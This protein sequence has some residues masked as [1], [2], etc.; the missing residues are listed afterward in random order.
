MPRALNRK[1]QKN[2]FYQPVKQWQISVF[3]IRDVIPAIEEAFADIALAVLSFEV[4]EDGPEWCVD[5]I[6]D[7]MPNK[8]GIDARLALVS[9]MVDL[10]SFR[11]AVKELET[12]NWVSEVERSFPPLSIGRFYVHGSHVKGNIPCG[13]IGLEINAGIA[14]GSGEHST[15]SGCLLAFGMLARKRRFLR[16]LDVG[17]GSGIL[18]LAMAKLWHVPVAGVDIDPV[19]VAVAAE[20]A[21]KN[22]VQLLTRFA[23][24]DGYVS[25][26]VRQGAPY[27]LIVANIL[28]R[29]L[30]DMA[31]ALA[32]NLAGNGIAVLSGILVKQERAVLAAHR[33]QGLKLVSSIHKNG[34]STLILAF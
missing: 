23:I 9:G 21:R 6:T 32:R 5:I 25:A 17:C 31:P 33:V 28:A 13:E 19:S 22:H 16:P 12:K 18:T 10:G 30:V 29:P 11:H 24:S 26:L 34:W 4:V 3:T 20:N 15:T 8:A 1:V 14:F 7:T 2:P 27:D